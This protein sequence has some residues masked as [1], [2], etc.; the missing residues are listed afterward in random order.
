MIKIMGMKHCGK[1]TTGRLLAIRKSSSFI[2]L[3]DL[4]RAEYADEHRT[5]DIPTVRTIY[6]SLGKERFAGLEA[7]ASR[8][9]MERGAE[10]RWRILAL[11]GGTIENADAMG[12]LSHSGP[13]VYLQEEPEILFDRIARGG[14]PPFLDPAAPFQSFLSLYNRRS[15]LFA[16][17]ADISVDVHGRSV[18]EA[19]EAI[20]TA[21]QEYFIGR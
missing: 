14:I 11:G 7:R 15:A 1:T 10:E 13:F 19:V 16:T 5:A 9:A 8:R 21:L 12:Y 20:D 6:Q 3:D 18:P 17:H 2:D 4:L